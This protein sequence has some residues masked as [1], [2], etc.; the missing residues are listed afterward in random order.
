ME[1]K[2][3]RQVAHMSSFLARDAGLKQEEINEMIEYSLIHL[4]YDKIKGI[5][6]VESETE[7]NYELLRERTEL[8]AQIAKRVQLAQKCEDIAR[9]HVEGTNS[10]EFLD[11]MLKIQPEIESQIILLSD[12]SITMRNVASYK[13]PLHHKAVL[14]LFQEDLG[15]YFD[16]N[17]KERFLR[18]N[19]DFEKIYNEF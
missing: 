3:A 14:Q 5:T 18:F 4:E 13:R 17:L 16:Y 7:F 19:Q 9:A 11:E 6:E 15:Y 10:K 2:H 12:L 8:G 1:E